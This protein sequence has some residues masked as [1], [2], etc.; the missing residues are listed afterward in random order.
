MKLLLIGIAALISL[1]YSWRAC[2]RINELVEDVD[3][4]TDELHKTQQAIHDLNTL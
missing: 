4:I 3:Q 1:L 2:D